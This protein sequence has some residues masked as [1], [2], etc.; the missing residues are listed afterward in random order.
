MEQSNRPRRATDKAG[1]AA[2]EAKS[3]VRLVENCRALKIIRKTCQRKVISASE[4]SV[5]VQGENGAHFAE[6]PEL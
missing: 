2:H 1:D 6:D 4:V 5:R 3:Q